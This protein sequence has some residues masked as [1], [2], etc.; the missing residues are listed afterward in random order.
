MA[1]ATVDPPV[2]RIRL[3]E[4]GVAWVA[5]Q[6]GRRLADSPLVARVAIAGYGSDWPDSHVTAAIKACNERGAEFYGSARST[7]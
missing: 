1:N 2:E 5:R 6:H 4:E 3:T 7:S